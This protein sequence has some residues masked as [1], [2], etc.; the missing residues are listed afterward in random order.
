MNVIKLYKAHN[1]WLFAGCSYWE[2]LL[3]KLRK[4][5]SKLLKRAS[6]LP[7]TLYGQ[8]AIEQLNISDPFTWKNYA[9]QT[10]VNFSYLNENKTF[11]RAIALTEVKACTIMLT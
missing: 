7:R 9:N 2:S 11:K 10:E 8:L 1:K 4:E 6:K 5:K 3:E